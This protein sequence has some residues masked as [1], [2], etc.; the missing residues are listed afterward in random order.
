MNKTIRRELIM[1]VFVF[2]SAG[3]AAPL[4]YPATFDD[5]V[6][7]RVGPVVFPE[8]SLRTWPELTDLVSE[9]DAR[10][11]KTWAGATK[12]GEALAR[13]KSD[14]YRELVRRFKVVHF[15]LNRDR[16]SGRAYVEED[17]V[18]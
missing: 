1:C 9:L 15:N 6:Q 2:M 11:V 3:Y 5:W 4:E 7:Q 13:L 14:P 8:G 17:M 16:T 10:A 12:P 18:E